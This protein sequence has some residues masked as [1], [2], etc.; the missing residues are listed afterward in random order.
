[1]WRKVIFLLIFG[2]WTAPLF[3]QNPR[4]EIHYRNR[5]D[6][7]CDSAE[8]V[9]KWVDYYDSATAAGGIR[10]LYFMSTM[11]LYSETRYSNF[12]KATKQGQQR[13][14]HKDQS[15]WVERYYKNNKADS[16]LRSFLP[17]GALRR[18]EWYRNDTLIRSQCY[19]RNGRDTA[20]YPFTRIAEFPGGTEA[21][22]QYLVKTLKYP[23]KARR[24]GI[25]GKVWIRF[26][27]GTDGKVAQASVEKSLDPLLDEVALQVIQSMP[28]WIPC[29]H[30]GELSRMSFNQPIR[31]RLE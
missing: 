29:I 13:I 2:I 11:Q 28:P 8:A 7:A 14:F 1:M 18:E 20:Y 23:K 10:K 21:W 15:L 3:S 5:S 6:K 22:S 16:V 31:F 9:E 26:V 12:S 19:A 27:I 4:I 30:N 25:E 17:N 24:K